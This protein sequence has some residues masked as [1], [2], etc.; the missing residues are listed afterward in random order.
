MN[1]LTAVFLNLGISLGLGL[2]VG[3]QREHAAASRL[4]GI[5]TFPLVTILGTVCG[6]LSQSFGGWIVALGLMAI[7]ALIVSGNIVE[8]SSGVADPG[9][10]TEVALLLMYAVGAYLPIGSREV[11]VTIGGGV[12]VLLHWKILL[13][14]TTSRLEENDL[15]QVMQFVLLS[16]VILPVLPDKAYGPYQVLNPHLIWLMVVLIVGINLGGYI[17]YK[18]LGETAGITLAGILG[19]MISST[20][21]TASY[22]RR[23]ALAPEGSRAAALVI[24]IASSV[25]FLRILFIITVVSP[26]FIRSAFPPIAIVTA[27]AAALSLGFW[28]LRRREPETMPSQANPSE[29]KSALLFGLIFA[30]VLLASAAARE[31][32]GQQGLYV[33]GAISG[34][35][36]IDAITLSTAQFVDSGNLHPDA[37]WRVILL[38]CMSNLFFKAAVVITLG[39]RHLLRAIAPIFAAIFLFI[40]AVMQFWP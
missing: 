22:S 28:F 14:Q 19:G 9:L 8:T 32:F 37:G 10:T 17:A 33:V 21:T 34:L 31:R 13:H 23:S 12:A 15:K 30:L 16:M 18:F 24:L 40:L 6:L 26:E 7:A 36:D 39:H 2:L 3:L 25:V 35:T 38:A 11:A 1:D 20:A 27:F 29:L 5:R 4:A